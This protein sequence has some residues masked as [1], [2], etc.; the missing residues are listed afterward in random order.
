MACREKDGDAAS[1]VGVLPCYL[2]TRWGKGRVLRL[3]G[4]G[5]ACSDHVGLLALSAEAD[6]AGAAIA[7][8]VAQCDDWDLIDFEGVDGDDWATL[9]F[10]DRLQLSDC[11]V[12]RLLGER[13]W[14]IELPATW[15]E[16]LALQSKSHRKQLR[17]MERRV[18]QSE[19]S[20]WRIVERADAFE[21]AWGTLIDLHQRRRKSLGEPGCF[22]SPRWAAFHREV[23]PRLMAEGRLRLS[24]LEL[25]GQAVA[26]E[27]HFA[28][29]HAT[30]A[31]Q[32]GVDPD[33]LA[34]DP[35]QLSTICSI[36]RAIAEG[37]ARFDFLRGD[38]PYKA[39]WRAVP[40][41]AVRLVAV[42]PRLW[43]RLRHRT[44]NG[45]RELVR[46]ARQLVA[47]TA[48]HCSAAVED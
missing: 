20:R 45:A 42:P 30:Y 40:R 36:K 34:D 11:T 5:E 17:Q 19:R 31:Y 46:S 22:V 43:P 16:F 12:S 10:F 2:E 14:A 28:D 13:C 3:L 6:D 44:W 21:A 41:Q 47:A 25:D 35:G 37:H 39:H 33:R 4:D 23:A 48:E 15:D 27:Y 8:H 9:R 1:L 7:A 24:T 32:G 18:L 38:E 29:E 26:A